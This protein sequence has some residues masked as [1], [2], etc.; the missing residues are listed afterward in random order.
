MAVTTPCDTTLISFICVLHEEDQLS[1]DLLIGL[2]YLAQKVMI[3]TNF[4]Y[5][6]FRN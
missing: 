1:P 4:R 6:E 5:F 3:F 2:K